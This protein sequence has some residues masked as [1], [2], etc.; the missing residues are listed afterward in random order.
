LTLAG[1]LVLAA[2]AAAALP[3]VLL[4]QDRMAAELPHLHWVIYWSSIQ[5][6][7]LV[8]SLAAGVAGAVIVSARLT[9]LPPA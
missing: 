8:V 6:S 3:I 1:Y 4:L 9:Y 7:G 2:G 5:A